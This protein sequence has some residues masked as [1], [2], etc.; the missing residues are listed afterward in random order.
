M[1]RAAFR[2]REGT[3]EVLKLVLARCPEDINR[4]MYW[5]QPLPYAMYREGGL[6]TP[7]HNVAE[8]GKPTA[9]QILLEAGADAS[10]KNS[11]GMTALQVAEREGNAEVARVLRAQE[12]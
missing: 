7:L 12:Q 3:D 11:R 8:Q 9:A 5:H 1:H 4:I 2:T 6:G 10:M